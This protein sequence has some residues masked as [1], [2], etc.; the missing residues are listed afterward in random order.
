MMESRKAYARCHRYTGNNMLAGP[1]WVLF[2]L[3]CEEEAV[4]IQ[5]GRGILSI[6]DSNLL[7]RLFSQVSTIE[8]VVV[9]LLTFMAITELLHL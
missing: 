2:H 1:T 9:T 7:N 5:Y 6:F 8:V 3:A 4:R